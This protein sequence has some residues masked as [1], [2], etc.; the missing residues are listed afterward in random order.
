MGAS[1]Q[2]LELR[3]RI[4]QEIRGY[5]LEEGFL[6]VQT[7]LL[8][9]APAPERNIQAFPVDSG[10]RGEKRFLAPSPELQMKRLL[11]RGAGKIFQLGPAF[12]K[13]ERGRIHLPEFTMLEWYRAYRDYTALMQ[14]CE[15][16]FGWISR[17]LGVPGDIATREGGRIDLTPPF[18]R[19]GVDEAFSSLAGWTPGPDPDPDR[20]ER[21]LV[22]RVEPGLPRERPVFLVDYPASMAS[23]ARLKP[24]NP[25][26]AERVELYVAGMELANGFSELTDPGEQARRFQ[27]ETA[28]MEAAGMEGYPWPKEFLDAMAIMPPCAGMALGV[29]R[30]IMLFAGVGSIDEVVA[31]GPEEA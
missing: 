19:L 5:F 23:L 29:D 17:G 24:G 8:V 15:R 13:G 3:A 26:V 14:D 12:R 18:L 16:L 6:E 28:L 11:A 10:R 30:L 31:F 21:D 1:L 2:V 22:T 25:R 4:I 27:E 7:P 9:R 20:F